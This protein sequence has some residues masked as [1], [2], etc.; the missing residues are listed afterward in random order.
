MDF[1]NNFP[2]SPIRAR[3]ALAFYCHMA[4]ASGFYEV[5]KNMLRIV[6]GERANLWPFKDIVKTHK[7]TGDSIA[8]NATAVIK[9]LVGHCSELGL[10]DLATVFRDVFNSDIRN[11]FAH[12]DYVVENDGINLP[13]RNGG[14]AT[15]ISW[16]DFDD[17]MACAM[18]MFQILWQLANEAMLS[19]EPEKSVVGSIGGGPV[20]TIVIYCDSKSGTF[21]IRNAPET[22]RLGAHEEFQ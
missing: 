14:I 9:D 2:A 18:S 19:Y 7:I 6:S 3:V 12:A 20:E 17:D 1:L 8:P 22:I 11:A 4:E 21:G 10:D 13:R 16:E 5:P 15:S